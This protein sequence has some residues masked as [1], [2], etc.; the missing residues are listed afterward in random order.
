ML[1]PRDSYD[2]LLER[3]TQWAVTT[4]CG[5]G[6][7]PQ[8]E[9]QLASVRQRLERAMQ[10]KIFTLRPHQKQDWFLKAKAPIVAACTGNRWGKSTAGLASCAVATFH[11]VPWLPRD[12]Q[13]EAYEVYSKVRLKYEPPIKVV[14]AGPDYTNWLPLVVMP[15]LRELLPLDALVT[16]FSRVQGQIIDGIEWWN[17]STWKILSYMG[18]DERFDGWSAHLVWWDEQ[19][20]H[21][22]FIGGSRGAIDYGAT[23]VMSYTPD[24]MNSPWTHDKVYLPGH[25][26]V[27]EQSFLEAEGKKIVIVEGSSTDNPYISK[28]DIE[29]QISLWG[30]DPDIIEARLHGKYRYLSGRVYKSFAR[31]KHVKPLEHFL[32][33]DKTEAA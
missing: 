5:K 21:E 18:E 30:G 1:T 24:K 9:A 8:G 22:K 11:C 25:H 2:Q 17:G 3:V 6:K 13:D 19:A 14:L 23:H 20:P 32:P 12:Q 33:K 29:M 7:L 31:E 10:K 4:E 26:V 28:D 15:T 16:R 27:D